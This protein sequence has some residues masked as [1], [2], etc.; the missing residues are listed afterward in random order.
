MQV[1]LCC[2]IG[3]SLTWKRPRH[4]GLIEHYLQDLQGNPC[5]YGHYDMLFCEVLFELLDHH[6]DIL[7]LD[8]DEDDVRVFDNLQALNACSALGAVHARRAGR[9]VDS[10]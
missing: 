9:A 1:M 6:R 2:C 10:E 8:R 4:T 7:R 5:S 3:V